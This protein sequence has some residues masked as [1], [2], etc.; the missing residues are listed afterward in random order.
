MP[1]TPEHIL[2][3]GRKWYAANKVKKLAKAKA[4]RAANLK[5]SRDYL[6]SHKIK[7][8]YGLTL[9][10]YEDMLAKSF[11]RCDICHR[12]FRNGS[13]E[14]AIDHC[15]TS[16]K[17]RGLLCFRCNSAIELPETIGLSWLDK[18]RLYLSV[19]EL[20]QT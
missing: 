15:H 20:R 11:G 7:S 13:R 3:S 1:K 8:L 17:V 10:E 9:E 5:T 2:A 4:W 6:K 12:Q 19:V 16:G 18:V 14:P